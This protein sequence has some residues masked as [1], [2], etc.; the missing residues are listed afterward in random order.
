MKRFIPTLLLALLVPAVATAQQR[1]SVDVQTVT[2]GGGKKVTATKSLYLN[3]DGRLVSEV[4]RPRHLITL[5]NSLG[6]MRIYNPADNS[7]VVADD[8]EVASSKEVVAMFASGRYVDM[9]LPLYGYTQRDVRQSDGLTVKTYEPKAKTK[10]AAKVELVFDRH[11]PVCMVYYGPKGDAVR[12]VY[13]S[14]YELGRIPM[15][16]RITE[17]E[18]ISPTDS[19]VTLSTYTNLVVGAEAQSEMFDFKVPADAVKVAPEKPTMPT[20]KKRR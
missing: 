15:P 20:N 7:V 2:V 12:K 6:E 4:H 10:G 9:D 16:M 19:V 18:Y 1:L 14:R 3:P 17:V 11:L 13:F 5:T 8:K